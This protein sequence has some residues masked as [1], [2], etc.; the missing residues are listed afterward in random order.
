[1]LKNCL[2]TLYDGPSVVSI[3]EKKYLALDA[4]KV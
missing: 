2:S 4:E 3:D 1:M